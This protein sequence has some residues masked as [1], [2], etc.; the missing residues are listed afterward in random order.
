[1]VWEVSVWLSD[2]S[3][4]KKVH[5]TY[6]IRV[7]GKEVFCKNPS[8]YFFKVERYETSAFNSRYINYCLLSANA[9]L[10]APVMI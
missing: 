9:T 1:M 4:Q 5:R 3:V 8:P 7:T 6:S 10:G 2:A